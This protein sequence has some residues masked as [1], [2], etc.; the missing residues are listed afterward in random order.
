MTDR[1]TYEEVAK[2]LAAKKAEDSA[3]KSAR[4]KEVWRRRKAEEA[5]DALAGIGR[6]KPVK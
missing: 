4:M 3:N 5:A 6:N 2:H 1:P